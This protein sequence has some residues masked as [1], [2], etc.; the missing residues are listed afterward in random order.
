MPKK[1][2][3]TKGND[4]LTGDASDNEINGKEGDDQLF[5]LGGDDKLKGGKGDDTLDGGEG[6]DSLKGEKG[7][8]I[9][10][11]GLGMDVLDG[12]DDND[13]LSGGAE[14]DL[15]DGGKGDDLLTG[16]EGNDILAGNKGNDTLLGGAGDDVLLGDGKIK[17]AGKGWGSGDGTGTGT[18]KGAGKGSGKGA[19]SGGGSG[20]GEAEWN[21]WATI[22]SG[23]K[24]SGSGRTGSKGS[25]SRGTG[26]NGSD[27]GSD[28]LDGGAGND[29]LYAWSGDDTGHYQAAE[30]AGATDSYD[31]GD[32]IDT[33][34]LELTLEEWM[35]PEFQ[36]DLE[37]YLQFLEDHTDA[38]TGEADDQAFTFN[39]FGLTASAWENIKITVDGN[40]VDPTDAAVTAQ[41][42]EFDTD[43]ESSI[44]GN[45]LADNGNGIDEA[46]D[47]LR[48]GS[49]SLVSG[50]AGALVLDSNGDFSYDPSGA[51]QHLAAGESE[52]DSF[53][54]EVE[55]ADGDTNTATASITV[56]GVNDVATLSSAIVDLTETDAVLST[57]GQL[58]VSD[59]DQGEEAFNAQADTAGDHGLF[60]MAADGNWTYTTNSAMDELEEGE[61][62]TDTFTVTSVD[63]TETSVTVNITG[64]ADGPTAF[65]DSNMLDASSP[66]TNTDNTV[67]WVDWQTASLVSQAEGRNAVYNVQ[68]TIS[69]PNKTIDVTYNGQLT[70]MQLTGGTDFYVTKNGGSVTSTEGIGVYTGAAVANGP[71]NNDILQFDHADSARTLTFSEP[72]DNLFFAIVSMNDNGYLFDQDFAV[73]SS[74]DSSSDSGYW[75]WS[76]GYSKTSTGDGRYGISTAG[77]SPNEFHGVLA[78]ENAVQSLTWTGQ[79]DEAWNGFTIATYGVAQTATVS[80]NVLTN[81]DKGGVTSTIEVSSVTEV[82]P[83]VMAGNSVTLT[84]DSGAILKV[85]RDG[86]YLYDDNGMFASLGANETQTESVE[87][88]VKDNHG[89]TD[90]GVLEILVKGVNDAPVAEDDLAVTDEDT[91]LTLN[92]GVLLGNDTDVDNG[93]TKT[94]DSVQAAINGT[95]SFNGTTD[96]VTFIPDAGY[97]GPASFSYTMKDAAGA[98]S[99][100]TVDITVAAVV[101]TY[102]P[103]NLIANGSFESGISSWTA[104]GN[105]VDVVSGWQA[106]DGNNLVDL[107]AFNPGGVE[108]VISTVAGETYSVGFLLARNPHDNHNT[109]VDVNVSAAADSQDYSFSSTSSTASSMEWSQQTFTFTAANSNTT[110]SFE[111]LVT[112]SPDLADG[113]TLDEVVVVSNQV[114]NDFDL[115]L[116]GDV[117]DLSALL[118]SIDAP[119]NNTAFDDDFLNFQ[120][121]GSDTLVQIDADGG[122]DSYLT[123]ATLVGVLLLETDTSNFTL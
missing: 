17:G 71:T 61:L 14:D 57:S 15:L 90:V 3:G 66:A 108:Q 115:G 18:G 4:V 12:G 40:E 73:V 56:T 117:L 64:T 111:S 120:Q 78:I 87:Y 68:G 5:G 51:Y 123:V 84:L 119:H 19:G 55:D 36:G 86:D 83:V 47:F 67:Y 53:T 35:D 44:L 69:L 105:G 80:G 114:I 52:V 42:D 9:L 93:D 100:A 31:G 85:D 28:Y 38:S 113:P 104:F 76:D 102:T 2:N 91:A 97:N 88:T 46:P 77:I 99:T 110:L 48:S 7:I 60:S 103:T 41:D 11:G 107:N 101:D 1:N 112:V 24:G 116:G 81:D 22:G 75:G 45:V 94:L 50:P 20:S 43:E 89:N 37:N 10:L 59:P 95:V 62:V 23:S 16:D 70:G 72:V 74:A 27:E 49:V 32:G 58:T 54:Y 82:N 63:G 118:T 6:N 8:D 121:S 106:G 34:E 29:L 98:T 33:L 96:V 13:E 30:N 65:D 79:A 21:N 92:A 39:A 109:T 122:G 26:S 25:G